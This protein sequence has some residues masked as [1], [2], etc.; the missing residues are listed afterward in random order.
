M[1]FAAGLQLGEDRLHT[2][3][4]LHCE[5]DPWAAEVLGDLAEHPG[6]GVLGAVDGV[7]EAHDAVAGEDAFADPRRVYHLVTRVASLM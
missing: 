3:F 4:D 2:A 6:A 7:T 5:L 1:Q